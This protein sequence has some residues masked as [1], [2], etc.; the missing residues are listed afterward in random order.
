MT[1]EV[2]FHG[3]K[4]SANAKLLECDKWTGSYIIEKGGT[5]LGAWKSLHSDRCVSSRPTNL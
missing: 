4:I 3:Y 2:T 5:T 1:T